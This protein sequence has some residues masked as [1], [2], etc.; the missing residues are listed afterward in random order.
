[1]QSLVEELR[2]LRLYGMA[3]T[4]PELLTKP[5]KTTSLDILLTRLVQAEQSDRQVRS[6]H[7]QMKVARFPHPRDLA[8][9][10]FAESPLEAE[11]IHTLAT[12]DFSDSAHNLILIGGTGT[13]KTHLS[14]ALGSALVHQGKR[15]RFFNV[16]DLVNMLIKEQNSG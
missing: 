9:F 6:L 3:E 10:N 16:V 1:M 7:Y 4:L 13:G 8:G 15:V 12:G 14:I 5:R 11:P 2:E